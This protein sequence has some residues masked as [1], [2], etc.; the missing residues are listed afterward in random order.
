MEDGSIVAMVEIENGLIGR[1]W[2][3]TH[4]NLKLMVEK[5]LKTFVHSKK[6][7]NKNTPSLLTHSTPFILRH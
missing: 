7:A 4:A 2:H 3:M 6:R 1:N 5:I